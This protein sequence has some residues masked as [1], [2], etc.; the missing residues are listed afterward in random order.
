MLHLT[1]SG[2]PLNTASPEEES[3]IA[4]LYDSYHELPAHRWKEFQ[5]WLIMES[6][7]GGDINAIDRHHQRLVA[8]LQGGKVLDALNEAVHLRTNYYLMLQ[9]INPTW[10]AFA[11][12]VKQI[13]GEQCDD[14]TM[15]G[16]ER[17]LAKLSKYK[18][19]SAHMMES[20]CADIKKNWMPNEQ[21]SIRRSSTVVPTIG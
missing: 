3:T 9:G 4:V 20:V 7:I 18:G 10:N 14:I 2:K 11:C 21:S 5:K 19:V 1:L 15:D 8:F 12:L 16:L 6:G 13:D 17:T